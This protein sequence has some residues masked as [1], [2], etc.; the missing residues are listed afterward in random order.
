MKKFISLLLLLSTLIGVCSVFVSCKNDPTVDPSGTSSGT[1]AVSPDNAESVIADFNDSAVI[2]SGENLTV[3]AGT[4]GK[5][6]NQTGTVTLS[7]TAASVSIVPTV[8]NVASQ[9]ELDFWV[10]NSSDSDVKVKLYANS[11]DILS[12]APDYFFLEFAFKPGWNRYRIPLSEFRVINQPIGWSS[13]DSFE[14]IFASGINATINFDTFCA[15]SQKIGTVYGF[16]YPQIANAVCFYE[17][18]GFYF[19][20][21]LR[22]S[23]NEND[24]TVTVK[25][26][27]DT[28]YVPIAVLA[29]HRGA[30]DI[31]VAADKVTFTYNGAAQEYVVGNAVEYTGIASGNR[32]GKELSSKII[33]VGGH[34]LVPMEYCAAALGYKLFYNEMGI[35]IYSDIENIYDSDKDYDTL[36]SLIEDLNY[37]RYTGAEMLRNMDALYPNDQHTRLIANQATFDRLKELIKTDATYAAWF[38]RYSAAHDTA[39]SEYNQ[40]TGFYELSDGYR[41]L[42][43]SRQVM[44]LLINQATMYK[45]TGDTA[46]AERVAR[47]MDA[48]SK[49]TDPVTG[50]KSWH[51]EHFLDTGEIM[52]GFSIGYDWCYDYFSDERK[53]SYED[54]VWEMGYGAALGFG[55]LY[56]WWADSN[57][58]DAYERENGP[59][60]GYTNPKAPYPDGTMRQVWSNN[61]STV[62]NGGMV[63]MALAFANVNDDFRAYSEILLD[64]CMNDITDCLKISYAP[65]GGYPEGPG[66]W[67]YG[68]TYAVNLFTALKGATGSEYGYFNCPGFGE[69]FYFIINAASVGVG[70]WNYHDA[71][72]GKAS[73]GMFSMYANLS[74]DTNIGAYRYDNLVNGS[75][76]VT[77]WDLL[78]YDPANY[79]DSIEMTLDNCYYGIQTVTFRS[80]WTEQGMFC[81]LHGGDNDASHG[82]TDIGN[83]ILEYNKTRFFID[84]GADEYNLTGYSADGSVTYFSTPYRYWYYRNRAE[85][86]NTLII[87]P[88]KVDTTNRNNSQQ[89]VS[90]T[91]K[92]FD[93]DLHAVSEILAFDSGNTMAYAVVDMSTAYMEANEGKRGM[94]VLD[95]RS[96]VIIQDEM[97]LNTPSKVL[98]MAH[99]AHGATYSVSDDKQSAIVT[100]NGLSILCTIVYKDPDPAVKTEFT[101]MQANYLTETGLSNT[102]GEYSRNGYYKLVAETNGVTDYNVAIVCTL[103]SDGIYDYKWTDINDWYVD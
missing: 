14:F 79:G 24:E 74:G 52:F 55:Q 57:N 94:W 81:G 72:V 11:E 1:A 98:W 92:N 22:Y 31:S 12:D 36:F 42:A 54:A 51:P 66:Y 38:K 96:T 89:Y 71:G 76:T 50:A 70:T 68:T 100:V 87:N 83:F 77:W 60:I 75:Y 41:L 23:L 63:N 102:V 59:Y 16:N 44:N 78:F 35:A 82:Q 5:R 21:Q 37:N 39:S 33:A 91:K 80:D 2:T 61:W 17:D 29:E 69:S 4:P 48:I 40:A 88:T 34:V 8:S 6:A 18:C 49:F 103:L 10:N 19:V 97:K 28:M 27:N 99:M 32:P 30:S 85:G 67:D 20:D 53:D 45:L 56:S 9:M 7:G 86:Q 47:E 62:C 3:D 93:Q 15:N 95:N 65:D 13:V 43:M 73:T 64:C 46:Y 26:D 84:M 25:S 101:V 90:A 58:M